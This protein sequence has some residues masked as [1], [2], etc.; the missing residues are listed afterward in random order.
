MVDDA[1]VVWVLAAKLTYL[2]TYDTTVVRVKR[3]EHIMCVEAG[4]G[5][6]CID[7][8]P[9]IDVRVHVSAGCM[10]RN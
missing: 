7:E 1:A 9:H 3:I 4:I 6:I 2:K 10:K 5:Y 8:R